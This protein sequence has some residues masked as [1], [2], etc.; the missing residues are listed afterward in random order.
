VC[1]YWL[2]Y[3]T[4]YEMFWQVKDQV[5]KQTTTGLASKESLLPDIPPCDV[6]VHV[7]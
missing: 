1:R 2:D 3:I 6:S 5:Q 7:S 4:N